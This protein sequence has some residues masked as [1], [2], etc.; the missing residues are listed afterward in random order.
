MKSSAA[1]N[2]KRTAQAVARA[3]QAYVLAH[4]KGRRLKVSIA[5][6]GGD[7]R[8]SAVPEKRRLRQLPDGYFDRIYTTEVAKLDNALAKSSTIDP[9]DFR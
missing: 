1:Q 7:I 4:P 9:A 3:V 5:P 6:D 2:R 8:V